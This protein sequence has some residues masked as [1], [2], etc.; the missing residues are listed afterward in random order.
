MGTGSAESDSRPSHRH[1]HKA[2]VEQHQNVIST[3]N[4]GAKSHPNHHGKGKGSCHNNHH[5]NEHSSASSNKTRHNNGN[6]NNNHHGNTKKSQQNYHIKSKPV[7]V[8]TKVS[9]APLQPLLVPGLFNHSHVYG[10][11]K[12]DTM[13]VSHQQYQQ[14]STRSKDKAH[15]SQSVPLSSF[16]SSP[17]A[18]VVPVRKTSLMGNPPQVV[19][20][21][22]PNCFFAG[23]KFETHP[24]QDILPSPPDTWTFEENSVAVR[25][26]SQP[27]TPCPTYSYSSNNNGYGDA[28]QDMVMAKT[29]SSESIPAAVVTCPIQKLLDTQLDKL[30]RGGTYSN[31]EQDYVSPAALLSP[32]QTCKSASVSPIIGS[33]AH[34]LSLELASLFGTAL[35]VT[36]C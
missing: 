32:G 19:A 4:K 33:K 10:H 21:K 29:V 3:A 9:S 16:F 34:G 15:H 11:S 25:S 12:S 1:H 27:S 30:M 22:K 20:G 26:Q 14:H 5:N 36:S 17:K 13:F 35:S 2:V 23:A 7:P 28:E 6:G 18:V 24:S 8:A 31:G